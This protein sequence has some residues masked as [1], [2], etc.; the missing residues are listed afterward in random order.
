MLQYTYLAIN[1]FTIII[2]F[3]FS[4]HPKIKFHRHFKAFLLSSIIV[5]LFF[6]AWDV[7]F[8][9]NG[10][11]WFN[12]K[13]LIGKRLFGLP[14]EELLFFIC[15]P[16]SCVFTY[17]CLDKFFKLNWK[18][19]IEKIFVIISIIACIILAIIFKDKTYSLITFLTT[20]ITLMVLYFVLKVKWIGKASFIY[21]V[22]MPGFLAVNGILTGTGL[23]SPIVNYNPK[24]FIGFR[25]LTIPIEDTV[26][27]YEMI[28]WNLFF[29]HK[30]KKDEQN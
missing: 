8:T 27:G 22:L 24:D 17:F 19:S 23:D 26:Y 14:I 1:F 11:W 30:L 21:L 20:A 25:I 9:A 15:I 2:C 18:L 4:F 29:F 12:D 16:F 28:L 6:I 3:I 7:W 13:Y 10:V 5:A